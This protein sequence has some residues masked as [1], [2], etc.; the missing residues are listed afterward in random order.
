[1]FGRVS[2]VLGER[3]VVVIPTST[4]IERGGLLGVFTINDKQEAH[5]RWLQL[6]S[7][8]TD[9]IEVKAGLLANEKIVLHANTQIREG[10]FINASSVLEYGS[11]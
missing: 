7:R 3:S 5:F 2:F 6:G 9:S 1:M 8:T 11:E 10:D 4:L